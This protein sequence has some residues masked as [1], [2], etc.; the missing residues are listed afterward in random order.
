MDL[1]TEKMRDLELQ[2]KN[3]LNQIRQQQHEEENASSS[4]NSRTLHHSQR[5][6]FTEVEGDDVEDVFRVTLGQIIAEKQSFDG[7]GGLGRFLIYVIVAF[8]I[9]LLWTVDNSGSSRN[10]ITHLLLRSTGRKPVT[11]AHSSIST[12]TVISSAQILPHALRVA[13]TSPCWA[14]VSCSTHDTTF[15]L[16][17]M[18]RQTAARPPPE[19]RK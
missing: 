5:S 10:E 9:A 1:M 13:G 14:R 4:S 17:T 3:M 8:A 15:S 18:R 12:P 16:L 2:N 11:T 19:S 6:S 7:F